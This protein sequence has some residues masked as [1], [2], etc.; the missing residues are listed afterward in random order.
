MGID[1][2]RF[3]P[4]LESCYASWLFRESSVSSS[5]PLASGLCFH[6]TNRAILGS[7]S[8]V[9]QRLPSDSGRFQN[10]SSSKEPEWVSWMSETKELAW[11]L[12]VKMCSGF[13]SFP[14]GPSQLSTRGQAPASR[15]HIKFG[16]RREANKTRTVSGLRKYSRFVPVRS[17]RAALPK[18]APLLSFV[19][20]CTS[21]HGFEAVDDKFIIPGLRNE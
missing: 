19:G 4:G 5:P 1:F 7:V 21:V 10:L 15:R 16:M 17:T 12:P 18:E 11:R 2:V 13:G 14:S 3:S 9:R 20:M 6:A 8:M